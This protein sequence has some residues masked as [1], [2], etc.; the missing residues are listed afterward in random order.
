MADPAKLP[1]AKELS[2][3]AFEITN[4]GD[5]SQM[6][7]IVNADEFVMEWPQSHELVRGPENATAVIENYPGGLQDEGDIEFISGDEDRFVL[8][9]MFTV[10]CL[11]GS[12]DRATSVAKIRYPDGSIW[13][14][15][16][17]TTARDGKIVRL[18]DYFCPI[19]DAPDWRKPWVETMA[20]EKA[21]TSPTA[22]AEAAAQSVGH[23]RSAKEV[24]Q[25]QW[26]IV[27]SGEFDRLSEIFDTNAV[28]EWPQSKERV[29]GV[30]NLRNILENFPGGNLQPNPEMAYFPESDEDRFDLT[31][32]MFKVVETQGYADSATGVVTSRY[33]DGTD[34]FVITIVRTHAGKIVHSTQYFAPLYEPPEWRKQW[35]EYTE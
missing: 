7:E 14:D 11:E 20:E 6:A 26:E 13:Y 30:A 22:G 23:E 10:V 1:S 24:V 25:R 27:N 8:T 3:R 34:W 12:H 35:V 32:V 16:E 18:V 21:I 33:P 29:R 4:R 2:L 28:I 9:P 5:I 17:M 15:V 19:Y 31:S